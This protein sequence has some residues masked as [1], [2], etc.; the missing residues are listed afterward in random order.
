MSHILIQ[1]YTEL[2]WGS[3]NSTDLDD[4]PIHPKRQY[5]CFTQIPPLC[6]VP[7]EDPELAV[8]FVFFN[9]Y[10]IDDLNK[11]W[12]SR[13]VAVRAISRFLVG[14]RLTFYAIRTEYVCP[15]NMTTCRAPIECCHI[16]QCLSC[17]KSRSLLHV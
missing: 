10:I 4:Q 15:L 8:G 11:V 17:H 7:H 14:V 16:L 9:E 6:F 3:F 2:S 12:I 13:A 1:V 5:I